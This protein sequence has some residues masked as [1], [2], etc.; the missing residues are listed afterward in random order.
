MA[1]LYGLE[2]IWNKTRVF[3]AITCKSL[4][5]FIVSCRIKLINDFMFH[6]WCPPVFAVAAD[7][8]N[9]NSRQIKYKK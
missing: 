6:G 3:K 5:N 7:K 1:L 4:I 2:G 8:F 9:H